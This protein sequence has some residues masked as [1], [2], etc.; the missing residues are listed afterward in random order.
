MDEAN[1]FIDAYLLTTVNRP[2]VYNPEVHAKFYDIREELFD[3]L[4]RLGTKIMNSHDKEAEKTV[5]KI[6]DML[7]IIWVMAKT[8]NHHVVMEEVNT[9]A[10]SLFG[11]CQK[12]ASYESVATYLKT[13]K[14]RLQAA[15]EAKIRIVFTMGHENPDMDTVISSLTEGFRKSLIDKTTA[16]IPVI[17]ST[18][19]PD[20]IRYLLGDEISDSI[21]L[22]SDREYDAA[23]NSGQA[24]W[25][26]VDHNVSEVQRFVIS[27]TDHHSLSEKVKKQNISKTCEIVG[28]TTTLVVQKFYGMGVDFCE[29]LAR[30]LYGAT[31]MD[32]ENRSVRKM[33][34]KDHLIMDDLKE[35]AHIT[36]DH[37]FYKDIMNCLLNTEDAELL[38][39]RDYKQDWGIFGFSVVKVK[40]AFNLTG[41]LLKKDLFDRLTALA[42][43]NN[44]SKNFPLTIVKIADYLDDNQ[45]VNR[46]RIYLIFN[47]HVLP[48]FKQIMFEFISR[49]IRNEFKGR[50]QIQVTDTFVD[51]WGVG[52][53]LSRKVTAPFFEPI[54]TDT[55]TNRI[56]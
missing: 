43:K 21:L 28:S 42:Q 44:K 17:Q 10:R 18:R 53:Q 36:D 8:K 13:S 7:G 29:R 54:V 49:I 9:I 50:A 31:L 11:D 34:F 46:E 23:V 37:Q 2:A 3:F 51:L 35:A 47:D 6:I 40:G 55:F 56:S 4:R 1:D 45:T 48:E 52:D 41:K 30:I 12:Q 26:L 22:T 19:I 16:Y 32:T 24:R 15:L 25:I 5:E 33:T 39:A 14:K 20:E 38:F 27:I